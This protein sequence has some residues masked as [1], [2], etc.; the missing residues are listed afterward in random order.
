MQGDKER[1]A[2][3]PLSPLF[4]RT[5]PGTSKSQ[6]GWWGGICSRG[7]ALRS[8]AESRVNPEALGSAAPP[9]RTQS[10]FFQFVGL[11]L[12]G[13]YTQVFPEAQ[14]LLELALDNFR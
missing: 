14:P 10:G 7:T 13:M 2:G 11:P 4:D 5:K 6:V 8:L 3:L 12:F 1:E 9:V